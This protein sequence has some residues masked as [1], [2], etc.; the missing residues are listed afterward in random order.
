MFDG[1]TWYM[2]KMLNELFAM[3]PQGGTCHTEMTDTALG[4][5]LDTFK[6][7]YSESMFRLLRAVSGTFV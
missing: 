4:S 6:Y 7:A 5:I 1:I 2:Q 3:T